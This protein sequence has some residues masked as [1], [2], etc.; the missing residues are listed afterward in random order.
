MDIHVSEPN[1]SAHTAQTYPMIEG[2]DHLEATRPP[3]EDLTP[4]LGR[5]DFTGRLS[6]GQTP[7]SSYPGTRMQ[8]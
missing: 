8:T 1:F 4:A 6:T 3:T 2:D 7:L 5:T